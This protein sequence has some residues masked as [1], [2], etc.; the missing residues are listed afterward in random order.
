MKKHIKEILINRASW[1]R[2]KAYGT[3]KAKQYTKYSEVL[4][5]AQRRNSPAQPYNQRFL[6][7]F[8]LLLAA[9][10]CECSLLAFAQDK[11]EVQTSAGQ[12]NYGRLFYSQNQSQ[13]IDERTGLPLSRQANL[14]TTPQKAITP[15][16]HTAPVTLNGYVKRSDGKSTVWVNQQPVQENMTL[17]DM[18]IGQLERQLEAPKGKKS[19]TAEKLNIRIPVNG[20]HVRLKAGQQFDP[21]NHQVKEITTVAKEKQLQLSEPSDAMT[22]IE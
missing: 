18:H 11:P 3:Q 8:L 16:P 10:C 6:K 2:Y 21:N 22:E 12:S 5:T 17:D 1:M 9:V 13:Q 7:I 19:S 15:R 20:Q 4:S 14:N